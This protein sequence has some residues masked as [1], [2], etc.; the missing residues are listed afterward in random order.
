MSHATTMLETYPR[1]FNLDAGLLARC[2]QECQTCAQ[3]CTACAD[4]CLSERDPSAMVKC[5]RTDL[6]CADICET[7]ARVLSRQTEYDANISRAIVDACRQVCTSCA[8]ECER[9]AD[10]HDHCRVCAQA[11]RDCQQ[12]CE[13]LLAAM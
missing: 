4:S 1:D 2:I 11:C 9:H 6:D 7:T 12:A 13:A 10:Q 5:I 8:D 3:T